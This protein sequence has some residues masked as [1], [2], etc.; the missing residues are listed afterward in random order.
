MPLPD[1]LPF[2]SYALLFHTQRH[3]RAALRD[4][5]FHVDRLSGVS[6]LAKSLWPPKKSAKFFFGEYNG[7]ELYCD[8]CDQENDTQ[9][10]QH[11]LVCQHCKAP[12]EKGSRQLMDPD[13]PSPLCV[14][15]SGMAVLPALQKLRT[16]FAIEPSTVAKAAVAIF[17]AHMT[18][19]TQAIF[20]SIEAGRSWP[21]IPASIGD[22]L[23]NPLSISGPTFE[24][25]INLIDMNVSTCETRLQLL[26]RLQ[27]DQEQLK[28]RVH[29]PL[30]EVKRRLPASDH[31]LL[32]DVRLRQI[33][34]WDVGMRA[35]QAQTEPPPVKPV[36]YRGYINCGFLWSAGLIDANTVQMQATFDRCHIS[37][38]EARQ[39]LDVVLGLVKA[40]AD[41]TRWDS[42]LMDMS[43]EVAA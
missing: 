13:D 35:K 32:D 8:N 41:E 21:N 16:T 18:G 6:S 14:L 1:R 42:P 12:F 43:K 25:F 28:L 3:S 15:L 31:A 37:G 38:K 24:Q 33:F 20:N 7:W 2:R 30:L 22:A 27:H 19:G 23:P 29:A 5:Q 10:A 39:A 17:N 4:V 36:D 9:S 26:Q 34:N 40:L 11:D